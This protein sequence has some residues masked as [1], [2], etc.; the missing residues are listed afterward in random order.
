M[1]NNAIHRRAFRGG[2]VSGINFAVN[3][4]LNILQVWVLLHWW[5][6]ETYGLWLSVVAASTLLTA[7]IALA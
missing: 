6:R 2:I 5:S 1:E 7:N 3:M 4:L